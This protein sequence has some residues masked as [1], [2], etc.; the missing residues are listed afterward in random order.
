M[1]VLE[2]GPAPAKPLSLNEMNGMH[3]A[4]RRRR[5]EPWKALAI[6]MARQAGL[7]ALIGA[8]PCTVTVTIPVRGMYRRDP[9]NYVPVVKAVVDGLVRAGVWPD[10]IPEYVTV[11]E[12]VLVIEPA[13]A[14]VCFEVRS[15]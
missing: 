4:D 10:D 5:T 7:P 3:W 2:L 14:S 13:S 15:P 12:P 6:V 9:H 8:A 11:N 1:V